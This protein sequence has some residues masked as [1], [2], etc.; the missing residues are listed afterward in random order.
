MIVELAVSREEVRDS[1]N[2]ANNLLLAN[3]FYYQ[4]KVSPEIS[5]QSTIRFQCLYL[6][7]IAPDCFEHALLPHSGWLSSISIWP[8]ISGTQVLGA[9]EKP[10]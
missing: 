9:M 3:A 1:G 4:M 8:P 2:L 5:S 7:H 10:L 6:T